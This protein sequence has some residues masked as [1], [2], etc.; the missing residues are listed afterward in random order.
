MPPSGHTRILF[1][2]DVGV[3]PHQK[4]KSKSCVCWG[5]EY[6]QRKGDR[7]FSSFRNNGYQ[8][9]IEHLFLCSLLLF[10]FI[11][12]NSHNTPERK[13]LSCPFYR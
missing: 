1:R 13:T 6:F 3:P 10:T 2:G 9:F 7:T 8:Y 11:T 5:R 12:F 4:K